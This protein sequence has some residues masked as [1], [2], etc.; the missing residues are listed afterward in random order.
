VEFL[1][2]LGAE[3][4]LAG[5][6]R[7]EVRGVKKLRQIAKEFGTTVDELSTLAK[8]Y[9]SHNPSTVENC[10]KNLI[11]AARLVGLLVE[12]K[13]SEE[14][15]EKTRFILSEGQRIGSRLGIPPARAQERH[16]H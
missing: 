16:R 13:Q 4:T 5:P 11:T 9:K 12:K 10:K 3:I 14:A 1:S 2:S 6:R 7:I 15:L 8:E